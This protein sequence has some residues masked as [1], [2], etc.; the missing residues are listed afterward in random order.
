MV[1]LVVHLI[2]HFN[3]GLDGSL[4]ALDGRLDSEFDILLAGLELNFF[5]GRCLPG[6]EVKKISVPGQKIQCP[7]IYRGS[8]LTVFGQCL[9]GTEPKILYAQRKSS[10]PR[11]PGH[12][13]ISSPA[14]DGALDGTLDDMLDGGLDVAL[15]G[16]H[17]FCN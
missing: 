8:L 3:G 2:V 5:L 9:P 16:E 15:H 17:Y 7:D 1:D 4:G 6:T 10:V 14:L 13:F 11:A 12:P